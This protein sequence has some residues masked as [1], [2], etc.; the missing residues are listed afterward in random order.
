MRRFTYNGLTHIFVTYSSPTF[1]ETREINRLLGPFNPHRQ[2]VTLAGCGLR[3]LKEIPNIRG[4]EIITCP[5]CDSMLT[6][7]ALQRSGREPFMWERVRDYFL[8]E[9]DD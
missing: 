2:L 6:L 4:P 5:D 1:G 7:E 9:E 3:A 8:Q